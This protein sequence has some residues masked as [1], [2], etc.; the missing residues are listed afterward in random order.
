[1]ANGS[2][3]VTEYNMGLLTKY[4]IKSDEI[5]RYP[6]AVHP[7]Q[8]VTLPYW[9]ECDTKDG[10]GLWFNEH[11]GNRIAFFDFQNET[12]TEYEVPCRMTSQGYISNALTIAG[13]KEDQMWFTEIT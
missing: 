2:A 5:T 11:K 10:K 13:D 9:L 12:L 3:W 1:M 6:T 7:V 8:I 4:D